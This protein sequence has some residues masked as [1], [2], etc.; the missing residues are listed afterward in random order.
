MLYFSPP[1][2]F[3]PTTTGVGCFLEY[4][5]KMLLLL[6]QDHKPQGNTW[7]QP[8]GKLEPGETPMQAIIR[9]VFEE[10]GVGSGSDIKELKTFF[11]S[12][13]EY[14]FVYHTFHLP[15]KKKPEI[16]IDNSCHKKY[17]WITAEEA[18]KKLPLMPELDKCI[19]F[20]IQEKANNDHP[21]IG[22]DA[23]IKNCQKEILLLKRSADRKVYPNLWSLPSGKMEWGE[24]VKEAVIREVKEETGLK[25]RVIKFT[26]KYY[27]EKG[28]HPTKTIVCLPH[29]CE[30]ASGKLKIN[31][32][33]SE[34]RWFKPKEI[35]NLELAFD[36]KKILADEKLI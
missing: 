19:E 14:D 5:G 26:G 8:A 3:N 29:Y 15:L 4:K 1:K 27:D 7:G 34:A 18:L 36:H 22:V 24:E 10:T 21:W 33:S 2:N 16:K 25:I 9:E 23:I 13:P 6:R 12:Y 32:E 11:V 20:F 30:V 17:C 31:E 28:R 35:K